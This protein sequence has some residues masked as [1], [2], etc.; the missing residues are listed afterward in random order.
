MLSSLR[1]E[2]TQSSKQHGFSLAVLIVWLLVT[3]ASAQSASASSNRHFLITSDIHFNHMADPALATAL[4]AAAPT[5][6]ESILNR[7]Q[8]TAFSPYGQD[9]NWWL[10]Q[11]ALDQMRKT[12]PHP[13]FILIT[14]DLLAHNF[15]NTFAKAMHDHDRQHYRAFVRKTVDFLALEFRRRF[16]DTK[17][18]LAIGNNDEECGN[19]SIHP[20][21]MFLI[22][23]ADLARN[24]AHA[25]DHF[26]ATWEAL[27]SYNVPLPGV[28]GVRILVL[29]TVFFSNKYHA[30]SFQDGCASVPPTGGHDLLAWLESNLSQAKQAN[31]KVWIVYHIPPGIDGYSTMQQYLSLSQAIAAPGAQLCSQAIVPMWVPAWTSKFDSL[32]QKYDTTV[33]AS[34]AGHTHTD[35]FRLINASG[36]NPSFV[37]IN[38]A[39][40][41]VYDQNPAFRV[42]TFT[43]QGTLSDQTTYYLTNLDR[44]SSKVAGRWKKEYTFS[45]EWKERQ[46]DA[47]G[48]KTIYNKIQTEDQARNQWFKLYNVS[49]YLP[50]PPATG[51]KPLF[52]AIGSLDVASYET[53]Y[54]PSTPVDRGLPPSHPGEE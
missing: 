52:C 16:G 1:G 36:A 11:S 28:P 37:L 41:P 30:A 39:V 42:A 43:A 17:I 54:C 10:L 13:A 27:G 14:G 34:L 33:V 19:Y 50:P 48:L 7:S 24:L 21:G 35:D 31:E 15:P 8:L 44:A 29:N 53:C 38:P 49:H 5:L 47:A 32:L 25:D 51:M 18:L 22:D 46:L 23:T 9:T 20:H 4:A 2:L 45:R 26:V 3:A 12:L 40:S 6:R